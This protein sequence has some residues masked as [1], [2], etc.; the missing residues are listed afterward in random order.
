MQGSVWINNKSKII[1]SDYTTANGVIHYIDT[2]LT[3]YNL[4]DKPSILSDKVCWFGHLVSWFD[5]YE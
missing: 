3:P 4:L 1:K 5:W 2:M